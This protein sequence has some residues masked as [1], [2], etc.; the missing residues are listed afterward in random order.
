[1]KLPCASVCAP[2][3]KPPDVPV[4]LSAGR[5]KTCAVFIPVPAESLTVPVIVF[6]AAAR[7]KFWPVTFELATTT[8]RGAGGIKSNVGGG[9]GGAP[10][11]K[12]L[13]GMEGPT[14]IL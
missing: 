6:P 4:E 9:G 13:S 3:P 5:A 8:C 2:V 11:V 10:G 14:P 12:K 7:V 1:M